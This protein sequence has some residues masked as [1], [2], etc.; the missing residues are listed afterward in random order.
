M[1]NTIE[2]TFKRGDRIYVLV[3]KWRCGSN[4]YKIKTEREHYDENFLFILLKILIRRN[5]NSDT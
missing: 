4:G 2:N 5:K 1:K 3:F